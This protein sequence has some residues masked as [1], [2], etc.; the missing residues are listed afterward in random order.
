VLNLAPEVVKE[1]RAQVKLS[2]TVSEIR[3][4][5]IFLTTSIGQLSLSNKLG[6]RNAQVGDEVTMWV[7][8]DKVV[9]DVHQ[10]DGDA[11][12]HRYI[13][14]NLTYVS[15]RKNEVTF[16]TPEGEKIFRVD[17]TANTFKGLDEGSPI[18]V[19]LNDAGSI[20]HVRKAD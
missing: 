12:I 14:G 2:G 4:G 13:T 1:V 3:P 8:G 16:W 11:S 9:I 7:N 18:T 15:D 10:K 19:E 5:L 20:I 17:Q 6:P